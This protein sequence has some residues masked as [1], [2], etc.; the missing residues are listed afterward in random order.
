MPKCLW[1]VLVLKSMLSKYSVSGRTVF[2]L[3]M[4]SL[5]VLFALNVTFQVDAHVFIFSRSELS[6]KVRS[7]LLSR[8]RYMLVSS[9]KSLMVESILLVKS[10]IYIKK[11]VGPSTD[12]CGTPAVMFR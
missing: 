1:Y 6:C 7:G 2:R 4:F 12:P 8:L 10:F 9:A 3:Q 5:S 11:R